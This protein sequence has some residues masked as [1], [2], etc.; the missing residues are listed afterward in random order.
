MLNSTLVLFTT[1]VGRSVL[2]I[3]AISF[4]GLGVQPPTPGW[5]V[6][7]NDARMHY[8]AAPH[9]IIVQGL[10]LF[11]LVFAVNM[12]GGALR[13]RFDVKSQEVRE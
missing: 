9:L 8:R 5:S 7:I 11:M 10:S 4:L 6:M 2:S 13:D 1:R 12:L 3:A